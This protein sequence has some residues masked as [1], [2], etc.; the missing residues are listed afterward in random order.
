[1]PIQR[2]VWHLPR[3]GSLGRLQQRDEALPDPGPGEVRVRVA[4]V[5]LNFADLFAAQGLYSATPKGSF[6]PGLECA[7]VIDALGPGLPGDHALAE[8]ERVV[9]LTPFGGY[10]TA[11]NVGAAYLRPVPAGWSAAQAAAWPAAYAELERLAP[12]PPHVGAVFAF[13]RA[14]D[15]QQRAGP[16][17]AIQPLAA[18]CSR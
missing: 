17:A 1:M 2:T 13:D 12:R 9:A 6:I 10:A 14:P 11:I 4:A 16:S 7:G 15:G 5:G 8:G 18:S 3:A